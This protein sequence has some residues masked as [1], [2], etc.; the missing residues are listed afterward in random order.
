MKNRFESLFGVLIAVAF[1]SLQVVSAQQLQ[2]AHHPQPGEPMQPAQQPA[3]APQPQPAQ[4]PHPPRDPLGEAIFPPEMIMQHTR[5]LGLT[6]E[7][8]IFMRSEI[9]R[10]TTRFNEL[11]WQLQDAV[12][13]MHE[14]MKS[15]SINEQAALA[16][17]E[18]VLDAEREIKR[19]H[20]GMAIRIKNKLTLEQQ[21]KLQAI[22]WAPHP[23][24]EPGRGPDHGPGGRPGHGP[25]GPPPPGRAPGSAPRPE[26]S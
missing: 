10:T 24:G 26:G 9:Q 11:Q 20:I 8:K 2:P 7:Q 18:K 5:E 22:R 16:Q 17:L 4:A 6:D 25:D 19:L 1:L 13:A 14:I 15:N 23:D 21:Q 3:P 12:E